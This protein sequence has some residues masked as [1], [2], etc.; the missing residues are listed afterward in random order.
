VSS[1]IGDR[2]LVSSVNKCNEN[3]DIAIHDF[4]IIVGV[5]AIGAKAKDRCWKVNPRRSQ[6]QVASGI[7]GRGP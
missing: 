6:C 1:H 4:L 7:G 2:D 3:H 5:W